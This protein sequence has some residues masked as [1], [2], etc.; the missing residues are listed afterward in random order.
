[1][2]HKFFS[3]AQT[4]TE[5]RKILNNCFY[6]K[7]NIYDIFPIV[8]MAYSFA[9]PVFYNFQENPVYPLF[10]KKNDLSEKSKRKK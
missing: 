8:D 7:M 9:T 1:M 6:H 3:A 5:I 4:R 10:P 2:G